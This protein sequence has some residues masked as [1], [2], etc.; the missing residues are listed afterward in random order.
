MYPTYAAL[1]GFL[2]VGDT[3]AREPTFSKIDRRL[4]ND[5]ATTS[6]DASLRTRIFHFLLLLLF[7]LVFWDIRIFNLRMHF[8]VKLNSGCIDRLYIIGVSF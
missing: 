7:M 2:L 8:R 6:Q 5:R 1:Y 4:L 3:F